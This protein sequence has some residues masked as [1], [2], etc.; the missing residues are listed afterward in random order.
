M[1]DA[2]N[3]LLFR[4]S[5]IESIK[6]KSSVTAKHTFINLIDSII[7]IITFFF[8]INRIRKVS[9]KIVFFSYSTVR[10]K[11]NDGTINLY[12]D[13]LS[14]ILNDTLIIN[15]E[16]SKISNPIKN[17]N[18][19]NVNLFFI[20]YFM[21]ILSFVLSKFKKRTKINNYDDYVYSVGR[22]NYLL[23]K[24][25]KCIY[26][27]LLKITGSKYVLIINWYGFRGLAIVQAARDLNVI[28]IDIQHGLA[29]AGN[30]RC[31]S[32]LDEIKRKV[33]PTYFFCWSELDAK[34]INSQLLD[35]TAFN[36]G[37][38]SNHMDLTFGLDE[39]IILTLAAKE[40]LLLI[41]GLDV[42]DFFESLLNFS[43]NNDLN[44]IVRPHPS[45]PVST[46]FLAG[47]A[48]YSNVFILDEI[49]ISLLFKYT[50]YCLGEWSAGLIESS[51]YGITTYAI[52]T[53]ALEYLS[54]Y[55]EINTYENFGRFEAKFTINS[56]KSIKNKKMINNRCLGPTFF[57]E[58]FTFV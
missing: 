26:K 53:K 38:L 5:N 57:K 20:F 2:I 17:K 27:A 37:K 8:K 48:K 36:T 15:F 28:S 47:I 29:A 45:F 39:S 1:N 55:N 34:L 56:E 3:E 50:H 41:L 14:N 9:N 25:Y 54:D 43:C 16:D 19:I 40:N 46:E 22:Y 6:K 12:T 42:P 52:G 32:N 49:P 13:P 4:S 35:S 18:T 51:E 31:Y 10:Y 11:I 58:F 7:A 44:I 33:L 23:H 30:H 24:C 21:K